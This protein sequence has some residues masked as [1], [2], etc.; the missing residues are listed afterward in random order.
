MP[1]KAVKTQGDWTYGLM[2]ESIKGIRSPFK[3]P[4][5]MIVT[6]A[7]SVMLFYADETSHSS[8]KY[9]LEDVSTSSDL[10]THAAFCDDKGL[11]IFG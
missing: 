4:A 11:T 2:P 8:A 3:K 5:L 7:G 1:F 9:D 6:K 10:L